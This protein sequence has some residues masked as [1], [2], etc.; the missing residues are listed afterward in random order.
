M[1]TKTQQR[2]YL[3]KK[4]REWQQHLRTFVD[5]RD[6]EALH[7]LRLTLKKVKA[8]ARLTKA[9]SGSDAVKDFNGLKKMFKQAGLIR[10]AG[11][12]IQLLERFHPAPQQYKEDQQ[13]I[14]TTETEKFI[15]QAKKHR[16]KGKL[17]GRRLIAGIHS[18]ST[19][20]IHD[21][22]ALQ[23]VATG[24]LLT[25]SGDDLHKARKQIKDMLYVEKLLPD[26]VSKSLRLDTEY[27]DQLQDAIGQWHDAAVVVAVWAGKD[28]EASQAMVQD[29]R[30]KEASVR[31]L[32]SEFYLRAHRATVAPA[33]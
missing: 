5:S 13:Q 1:L 14:Q 17:A 8:L 26:F 27:L 3:N 33:T 24:I 11:N 32:A 4:N 30:E 6:P 29:C 23:M 2:K 25:A 18:V 12:H 21:W 7:Q 22:Y 28:L 10:D 19:T 15:R 16:R 20:S 9:C 31:T